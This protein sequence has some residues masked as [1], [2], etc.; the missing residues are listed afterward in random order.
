MSASSRRLRSDDVMFPGVAIL[1]VGYVVIGFW[2]SYLGA[3]LINAR[4]PSLLVHVHAVLFVGWMGLIL[5]QNALIASSKVAVHRRL[6][7]IMG[8][9]A[10]ALVLIGVAT[11]IM[12][13]RRPAE[14]FGPGPFAGNLSAL[15]AF[16]V[17]LGAG[18]TRRWDG[19]TH[20]RLMTLA[21]ASIMGPALV[22][23]PFDFIQQG[24]PIYLTFFYLLPAFM[25]LGYDVAMYRRVF[26]S[27]WLG[28]GLM[29]VA[30]ASFLVLPALP[31]WTSFTLWVQRV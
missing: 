11:S 20:K 27:T 18:Y 4:L 10:A 1:M 16:V 2:H 24:P 21:S 25:I 9:W 17:L 31:E 12:A 22:R 23:W 28:L 8:G 19:P 6:G 13:L 30:T 7:A 14:G 5:A 15:L 29:V 26:K 3:G